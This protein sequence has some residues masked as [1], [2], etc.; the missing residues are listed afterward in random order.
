M[1]GTKGYTL[2]PDTR[3]NHVSAKGDAGATALLAVEALSP[4]QRGNSIAPSSRCSRHGMLSAATSA[5]LDVFLEA[6][7][8]R[9]PVDEVEA[10]TAQYGELAEMPERVHAA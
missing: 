2:I 1:S 8:Q 5:L 6:W 9:Q 3:I 7:R 4:A 10:D